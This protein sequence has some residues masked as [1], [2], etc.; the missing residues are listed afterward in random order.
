M[1]A[2]PR[3]DPGVRNYRTGLLPQIQRVKVSLQTCP[4]RRIEQVFR[5]PV[6]TL[7]RLGVRSTCF[8]VRTFFGQAPFLHPL[9]RQQHAAFVRGLHRYYEPVRLPAFVHCRRTP[10]GF[11][12][13]TCAQVQA[14]RGI[15]RLPVRRINLRRRGRLSQDASVRAWGLGSRGVRFRSCDIVLM[16]C[17][18]PRHRMRVG[19][20]VLEL[21][22]FNG[23][24]ARTPVNASTASLR[25]PPH[26][27]GP[28]WLATPSSYDSLIHNILP[29]SAGALCG[30]CV[31]RVLCGRMV[32]PA[33]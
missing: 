33:N 23:Q 20:P 12:A 14:K 13:R 15:S 2:A 28:M 11:T 3:T 32:A 1:P 24:P 31:L 26:D 10:F 29:A 27:S 6:G 7:T 16:R 5:A 30:L 9:R 19:T 8:A 22:G 18:L 17:G 21:S 25:T 4:P